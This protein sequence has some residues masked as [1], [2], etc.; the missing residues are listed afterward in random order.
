VLTYGPFRGSWTHFFLVVGATLISVLFGAG[1]MRASAR[2]VLECTRGSGVPASCE[3][4][5]RRLLQSPACHHFGQSM[6]RTVRYQNVGKSRV[7]TRGK[8]VLEDASGVI[9]EIG[10]LAS[11][12][13]QLNTKRLMDFFAGDGE[14]ALR[15]EIAP[16]YWGAGLAALAACLAFAGLGLL[17]RREVQELAAYRIE[18]QQDP[19]DGRQLRI[20]RR[21]LGVTVGT[22]VVMVPAD[23]VAV[24]IERGPVHDWALARG[25][26][27]PLGG[28]VVLR[29]AHGEMLPLIPDTRRGLDIHERARAD[30]ARCLGLP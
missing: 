14:P 20:Y 18:V 2:E 29:T 17:V 24:A 1:A 16:S 3:Y 7:A 15:I 27:P 5:L 28:R 13:A 11:S 6:L 8:T 22:Q 9:V 12:Q 10:P 4:C 25:Q 23:V 19:N 21:L 26:D 30:L